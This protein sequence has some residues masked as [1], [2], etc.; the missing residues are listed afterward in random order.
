MNIPLLLIITAT[1]HHPH[2]HV[3]LWVWNTRLHRSS[4]RLPT[5]SCY[6]Q[7]SL[8]R[9]HQY[10]WLFSLSTVKF[11]F[12]VVVFCPPQVFVLFPP[13]KWF[14]SLLGHDSCL[15]DSYGTNNM[16]IIW[17]CGHFGS[18]LLCFG[19]ALWVSSTA[20]L[21]TLSPAMMWSWG[22]LFLLRIAIWLLT[23]WFTL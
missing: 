16:L 18:S 23:L 2:Q 21:E 6:R 7:Q 10:I 12:W 11:S 22:S 9:I 4:V 8:I 13:D 15:L 3:S 19:L 20:S 17:W 5:P 14:S 1:P